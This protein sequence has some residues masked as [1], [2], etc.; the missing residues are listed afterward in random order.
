[1]YPQA[2]YTAFRTGTGSNGTHWQFTAKC[3]GCTSYSD[4]SGSRRYLDPDGGNRLAFAY[5]AQ[6]PVN[7]ASPESNFNVHDVF[8]YWEHD[9]SLAQNQDFDALVA[10]NGG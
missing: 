6:K 3:S 4:A 9:F 10:R 8:G 2:T 7:P 5:A 1:M